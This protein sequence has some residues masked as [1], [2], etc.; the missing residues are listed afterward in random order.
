MIPRLTPNDLFFKNL[1]PETT[2]Q[3]IDMFHDIQEPYQEFGDNSLPIYAPYADIYVGEGMLWMEF[4]RTL[5]KKWG[6]CPSEMALIKYLQ[7]Y[8]KSETNYM[9][10]CQLVDW[11]TAEDDESYAIYINEEGES[12]DME[13][14]DYVERYG[15]PTTQYSEGLL[16]F[17]IHELTD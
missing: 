2:K 12:N 3:E 13:V 8:H 14:C 6:Y 15:Y 10:T 1:G 16:R 9:V 7:E 11:D 4:K 5:L 17:Q